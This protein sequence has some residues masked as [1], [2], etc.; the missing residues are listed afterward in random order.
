MNPKSPWE[1]ESGVRVLRL[2]KSEKYPEWPSPVLK[3]DMV[4]GWPRVVLL[5]LS[6]EQFKE[7]DLDPYAFTNKYNLY[8]EQPVL[9]SSPCAKPPLGKTI[10]IPG[11]DCRWIVAL[12]HGPD[13]EQT[14]AACPQTTEKRKDK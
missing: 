10:P 3:A 12:V 6:A 4:P 1:D 14:V 8:S 7:F 9:W 5:D 2:Y 13:S 11:K